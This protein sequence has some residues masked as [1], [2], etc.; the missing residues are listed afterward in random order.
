MCYIQVGDVSRW[1]VHHLRPRPRPASD[2]M[3][4]T[5]ERGGEG[6][7]FFLDIYSAQENGKPFGSFLNIGIHL[8]ILHFSLWFSLI[9]Y[10]YGKP[11]L[12]LR[13]ESPRRMIDSRCSCGPPL[14][15]D[16]L[17]EITP[18]TLGTSN[19]IHWV[20]KVPECRSEIQEFVCRWLRQLRP[21]LSGSIGFRVYTCL[22]PAWK[23]R[24][25]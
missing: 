5:F 23:C 22:N 4:R 15:V 6:I 8:V 17:L 21:I 24:W 7:V 11:Q 19:P 9:S 20:Q 10:L 14:L 25:S 13:T 18:K 12:E 1:P 16:V 3:T 2:D